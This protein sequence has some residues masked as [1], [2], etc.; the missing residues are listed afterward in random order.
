MR[1]IDLRLTLDADLLKDRHERLAEA[2]ERV[3]RLPYVD[4]T[5]A[6]LALPGN[7]R[8]QTLDWPVSR[9]LETVLATSEPAD[10]LFVPLL[11]Q[12]RRLEDCDDRH[13]DLLALANDAS[14]RLGIVPIQLE[15]S[16]GRGTEDR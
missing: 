9:R 7:V 12:A 2:L 5:E 16:T 10:R 4:D 6:V 13:G 15:E 8:Q 11:R 14:I 3:L 1:R